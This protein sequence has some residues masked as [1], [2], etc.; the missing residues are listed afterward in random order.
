[1]RVQLIT[2]TAIILSLFSSTLA[3]QQTCGEMI[4]GKRAQLGEIIEEAQKALDDLS[5]ARNCAAV[6]DEI[7]STEEN[8]SRQVEELDMLSQK[9]GALKSNLKNMV[10]D[11]DEK[12][13]QSDAPNVQV[14]L[15][16]ILADR[17]AYREEVKNWQLRDNS[18]VQDIITELGIIESEIEALRTQMNTAENWPDRAQLDQLALQERELTQNLTQVQTRLNALRQDRSNPELDAASQL[19]D[20]GAQRV[21]A[22]K[23]SVEGLLD[24]ISGLELE[25]SN[26]TSELKAS[27]DRISDL[28]R[29]LSVISNQYG[30]LKGQQ[31]NSTQDLA[32]A[33]I[34]KNRLVP[35]LQSLEAQ[36]ALLSTNLDRLLPQ[37]QA[38]QAI[39]D[40]LQA[41]V[42]EK[43][44]QITE[45]ES[46]ISKN[47]EQVTNLQER[48]DLANQS[49][50]DIRGDMASAYKPLSELQNVTNQVF[51]LELTID[52]LDKEI[53]NLDMRASGAEGKLNRFI[54]ACKREPACKAALSL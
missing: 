26:Q 44:E 23:D 8:S 25:I 37:A 28:D 30:A 10:A 32:S 7:Q 9:I 54:R 42:L 38:I 31:T 18:E 40:Q 53:D 19:Q 50:T 39:V 47:T 12:I 41:S 5:S 21:S 52:G 14:D 6:F 16:V 29:E 24:Q 33:Q 46:Q 4:D 1:M 3:A 2:P 36:E 51:A 22:L 20:D 17:L 27:N 15:N 43:S 48:I 34:E 13:R 35:I 49:I 11:I 45:L